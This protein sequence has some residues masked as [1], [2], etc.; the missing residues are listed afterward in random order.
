[1]IKKAIR[2]YLQNDTELMSN[3]NNVFSFFNASNTRRVNNVV[4]KSLF[5]MITINEIEKLLI[6]G[7]VSGTIRAFQST[8]EIQLD[9]IVDPDAC[10]QKQID[11]LHEKEDQHEESSDRII[12]LLHN[13][14][15]NVN[16]VL[17][18]VCVFQDAQDSQLIY[19]LTNNDKDQIVYRK[20]FIFNINYEQ[21]A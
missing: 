16:G 5:P 10:N 12:E 6:E 15:G 9:T 20:T 11:N 2:T 13:L 8:L 21:G 3:V 19:N 14:S 1:M 7:H 18:G 17:V 4:N